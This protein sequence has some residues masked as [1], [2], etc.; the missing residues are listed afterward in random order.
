MLVR[1]KVSH[2]IVTKRF[3]MELNTIPNERKTK[4]VLYSYSGEWK[5]KRNG[6]EFLN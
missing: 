2:G 1:P 4:E 6:E 3:K 5:I